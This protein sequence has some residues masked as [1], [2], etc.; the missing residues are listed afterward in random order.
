M[1]SG[2]LVP[3][4]QI[5][6]AYNYCVPLLLPATETFWG[7]GWF[8]GVAVTG[9]MRAGLY[10]SNGTDLDLL[11]RTANEST[12]GKTNRYQEAAFDSGDLTLGAGIYWMVIASTHTTVATL[13]ML[14]GLQYDAEMM[15]CYMT[16][17]VGQLPDPIIPTLKPTQLPLLRAVAALRHM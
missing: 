13:L 14:T 6:N 11:A 4:S 16:N 9:S 17:N 3:S 12:T 5:C 1:A 8:N 2:G 10:A 15:D 7:M